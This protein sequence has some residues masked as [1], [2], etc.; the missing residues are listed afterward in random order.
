MKRRLVSG[1]LFFLFLCTYTELL[2]II[3]FFSPVIHNTFRPFVFVYTILYFIPFL[4]I[5]LSRFFS[6]VCMTFFCH[7]FVFLLCFPF[8]PCRYGSGIVSIWTTYMYENRTVCMKCVY[9]Q[10]NERVWDFLFYKKHLII[11]VVVVI[12]IIT[13]GNDELYTYMALRVVYQPSTSSQ[14]IECKVCECKVVSERERKQKRISLE[15]Q[16]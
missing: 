6:F 5:I 13:F 9:Q 2:N 10:K 12:N 14:A 4:I 7:T 16:Q 3:H 8:I 11:V 1:R 15:D